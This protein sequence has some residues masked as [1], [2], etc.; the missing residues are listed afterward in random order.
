MDE[1]GSGDTS[2]RGGSQSAVAPGGARGMLRLGSVAGVPVYVR[3]SWFVVAAILAFLVGPRIEE[4]VPALGDL[5][6]VA[7]LLFAVLLYL[8]V[9][10]HEA[11]HALAA[12]SFGLT[13]HSIELHFLGGVTAIERDAS[14]A[15]RDAVIAGVG[16]LTSLLIGAVCWLA[17]PA[18]PDGLALLLVQMLATANLVIGVLNLLPG[19]PLDGGRLLQAAVWGATGRPT[20]GLVAAGWVGRALAV[21]SLGYLLI[22][23]RDRGPEVALVD[24]I[25]VAFVALFLWQGASHA[26]SQARM[27]AMLPALRARSLGRRALGVPYELP[28]G[29]AVRRAQDHEAGGLVVLASDGQP[30]GIVDERAVQATP[31]DRR[32]WMQTGVLARSVEPG[33]LLPADLTGE[34]LLVAM[35]RNPASEYVLVEPDG[36]VFGVLATTDVDAVF[37]A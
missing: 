31:E 19:L 14:S 2:R 22:L 4:S 16:P 15:R 7:G 1:P 26:L 12:R 32:P 18:A 17:V 21:L 27:Q 29:E 10:L 33:L 8:S 25:L 30:T 35:L 23:P 36:S 11:S 37:K 6:Y 3:A 28:L 34:P 20:A 13:V 24:A 9:L 5:A